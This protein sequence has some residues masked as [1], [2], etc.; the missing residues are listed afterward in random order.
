MF[1]FLLGLVLGAIFDDYVLAALVWLL[2]Y[3]KTVIAG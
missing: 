2:E 3:V 1:K